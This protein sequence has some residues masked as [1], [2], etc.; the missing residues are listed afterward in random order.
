MAST[1][2]QRKALGDFGERLAARHL[3]QQGLVVLD[4]NWRCREGEIDIVA[5]DGGTLVVCEVKTRT[6]GRYGRPVE[7]ITPVKAA[8]LHRLGWR[9]AHVHDVR[10]DRLRV[11][12]VCILSPLRGQR[13]L[14]H[15]VGVG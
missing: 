1:H 3:Q 13:Q 8:R 12:V 10:F 15:L 7:A 6:T 4:R 14:E 11:D 5:R 2:A 9:W